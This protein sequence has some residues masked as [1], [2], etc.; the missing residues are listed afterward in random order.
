VELTRLNCGTCGT[1]ITGQ[2]SHCR[3]CALDEKRLHFIE[4]FLRCR[5][6]IKDVERAL[7]VSY[8]MVKSM[9]DDALCAMGLDMP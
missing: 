6:S 4:T 3:F 9:L 2:F 1:E 7:G 5:G 8:P